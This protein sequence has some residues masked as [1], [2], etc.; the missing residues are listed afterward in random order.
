MRGYRQYE[1]AGVREIFWDMERKEVLQGN[2]GNFFW[3]MERGRLKEKGE[4]LM[5]TIDHQW[6]TYTD[7]V[8]GRKLWKKGAETTMPRINQIF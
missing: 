1:D 3:V 4:K 5:G 6:G 7:S 2:S 8:N